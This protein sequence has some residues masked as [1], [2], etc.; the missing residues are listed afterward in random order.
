MRNPLLVTGKTE[1][2]DPDGVAPDMAREIAKRL[3]VEVKLVPYSSPGDLADAAEKGEWEVALV[4]AEP[5]RAKVINFTSAYCEIEATYLVPE[6]SPLA[7]I[8][9]VDKKGVRVAA[10]AR[11]A[12]QLWLSENLQH[13]KVVMGEGHDATFDVFVDQKLDAL[14]GLRDKLGKEAKKLPGSKVLEGKFTSVLQSIGVP[15]GKEACVP[16]LQDLVTDVKAN[17]FVEESIKRHSVVGKLS[18]A[19]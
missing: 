13:A 11:G 19:L 3:G 4:A 18:V 8:A 5:A 17:G 6:G 2:G 15:K 12:Y 10:V 1:S 16:F 14:A 9:D 7:T